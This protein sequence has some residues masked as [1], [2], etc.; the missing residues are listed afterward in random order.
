MVSNYADRWGWRAR[1]RAIHSLMY[2]MQE[3]TWQGRGISS[4]NS[5]N[6]SLAVGCLERHKDLH[7]RRSQSLQLEW[8]KIGILQVIEAHKVSK[9]SMYRE[10]RVIITKRRP[11]W[12]GGVYETTNV[13]HIATW[14]YDGTLWSDPS[15]FAETLHREILL[16]GLIK[17]P[18]EG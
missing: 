15:G 8:R 12:L 5:R 11:T 18:R 6:P 9:W 3:K 1:W 13:I 4:S 7:R 2:G 16:H 14:N 17:A 10:G